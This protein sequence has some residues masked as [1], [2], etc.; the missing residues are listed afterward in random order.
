MMVTCSGAWSWAGLVA[1]QVRLLLLQ[2]CPPG[3]S[4]RLGANSSGVDGGFGSVMKIQPWFGPRLADVIGPLRHGFASET[5]TACCF[6]A[7]STSALVGGSAESRIA[8]RAPSFTAW[9]RVAEM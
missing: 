4:S 6:T 3:A 5:S 2:T 7:A 8:A 1:L 9:L